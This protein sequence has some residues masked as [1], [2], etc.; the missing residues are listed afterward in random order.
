[1]RI[2]ATLK[3]LTLVAV[4]GLASMAVADPIGST[5][6]Q[7][8]TF[9]LS[10]QNVGGNTYQVTYNANFAGWTGTQYMTGLN[11]K[12]GS[13]NWSNASLISG[14]ANW[15]QNI[16]GGPLTGGNLS[17]NGCNSQAASTFLCDQ[18]SDANFTSTPTTGSY[19]WVYQL[20]FASPL[21]EADLAD[22]HIG[23]LFVNADGSSRGILSTTI[24]VPEP[25]S[26]SLLGS[27]LIFLAGF[28]R[29][30][31]RKQSL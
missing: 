14:P 7:G 20:T 2:F 3:I 8:G 23:A 24:S 30:L 21:T 17:Q 4:L 27:C 6:F 22:N 28:G 12:F 13:T 19:T 26:L 31:G 18:L 5:T 11:F 10:I 15:G 25:G 1:M 16:V 29:K 9:S